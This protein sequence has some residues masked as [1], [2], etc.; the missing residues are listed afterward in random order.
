MHAALVRGMPRQNDE[1]LGCGNE[2]RIGMLLL[3][4]PKFLVQMSC[5]NILNLRLLQTAG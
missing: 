4:C 3:T 1:S 5:H 2:L